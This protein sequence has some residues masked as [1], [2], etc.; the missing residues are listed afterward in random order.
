MTGVKSGP[1]GIPRTPR[2]LQAARK[3]WPRFIDR[4]IDAIPVSPSEVASVPSYEGT[5]CWEWQGYVNPGN[6]YSQFT[7]R[8]DDHKKNISGHRFSYFFYKGALVEGLVVRH[9]CHNKVCVNPRHLALGSYRDNWLDEKIRREQESFF[10]A[11]LNGQ[12]TL[13]DDVDDEEEWEEFLSTFVNFLE[14]RHK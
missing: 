14:E 11:F 7:F 12:Q 13:L 10:N 1:R 8:C 9:M 3:A 6:G 5:P 2:N 4:V